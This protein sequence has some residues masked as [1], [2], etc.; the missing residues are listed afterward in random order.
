MDSKERGGEGWVVSAHW[1]MAR[2]SEIAS[3]VVG[4]RIVG[5]VW[6]F[7]PFGPTVGGAELRWC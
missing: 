3:L 4:R 5:T 1:A 2:E 7:W 6:D